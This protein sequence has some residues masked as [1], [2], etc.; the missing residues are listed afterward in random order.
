MRLCPDISTPS[1]GSTTRSLDSASALPPQW[2]A[3]LSHDRLVKQIAMVFQLDE[4]MLW[5]GARVRVAIRPQRGCRAAGGIRNRHHTC[6]VLHPE[7]PVLTRS[8]PM[9]TSGPLPVLRFPASATPPGA[10]LSP[11]PAARF[12]PSCLGG[13]G[14][15]DYPSLWPVKSA[16]PMGEDIVPLMLSLSTVQLQLKAIC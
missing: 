16:P 10:F 4:R 8:M 14:T 12:H 2:R 1:S 13:R 6:P 11:G 3:L 7:S 15:C 9:H 5:I